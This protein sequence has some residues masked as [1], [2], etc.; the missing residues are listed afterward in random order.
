MAVVVRDGFR[1]AVARPAGT[2]E[3]PPEI[4]G[5]DAGAGGAGREC[6]G[7]RILYRAD[8]ITK[9]AGDLGARE[10]PG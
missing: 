5:A 7:A 8:N 3:D 1:A 4:F 6:E 2:I 9:Q 10:R